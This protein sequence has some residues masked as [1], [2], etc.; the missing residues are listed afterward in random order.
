MKTKGSIVNNDE[1]LIKALD[2]F[3]FNNYESRVYSALFKKK[4][5]TAAEV[6]RLADIPRTR[7]YDNLRS[8]EFKGLCGVVNGKTKLYS[9]FNPSKL[10][11]ILIKLEHD[12]AGIKIKRHQEGIEKEKTRLEKR[13]QEAEE[14]AKSLIPKY[15]QSRTHTDT[16]DYI[17][18]HKTFITMHGKF[19][20]LCSEAQKEILI[21]SKP[22]YVAPTYELRR[23]SVIPQIEAIERGVKLKSIHEIPSEQPDRSEFFKER[24]DMFEPDKEEMKI[25]DK[26]PMKLSIF[27]EKHAMFSL[28]DPFI[29][30]L[31]LVTFVVEDEAFAKS[32]KELFELYWDKADDL[33][34][35]K[36]ERP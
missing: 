30:E 31:S 34:K 16:L 13:A 12:K 32:F 1:A 2:S 35:Y 23:E 15:E 3:G 9:L 6:A 8:L 33:D 26:L 14:L 22:P 4:R 17:E 18:I 20:Q 29:G 11:D 25:I 36:D 5:L 21:F 27:D 7:A 19:M 24:F 10:K 28:Y